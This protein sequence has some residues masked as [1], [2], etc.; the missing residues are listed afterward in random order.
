[1]TI[2]RMATKYTTEPGQ[3]ALGAHCLR[4]RRSWSITTMTMTTEPTISRS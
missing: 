1:M 3:T 2:W 4:A